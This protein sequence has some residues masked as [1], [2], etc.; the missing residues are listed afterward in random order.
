ML[1]TVPAGGARLR[2]CVTW[3]T[4]STSLPEDAKAMGYV[5]LGRQMQ[6]LVFYLTRA[7]GNVFLKVI[8]LTMSKTETQKGL[9]IY[10]TTNK[11]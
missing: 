2:L 8:L 7:P 1:S 9:I 11:G 6:V 3:V 5:R 4:V 10:S